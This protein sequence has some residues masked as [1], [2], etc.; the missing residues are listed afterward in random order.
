[1]HG[2]Q[3]T[4]TFYTNGKKKIKIKSSTGIFILYIY[5]FLFTDDTQQG[6]ARHCSTSGLPYNPILFISKRHQIANAVPLSCGLIDTLSNCI[7]H[8]RVHPALEA[9]CS[10]ARTLVLDIISVNPGHKW[11]TNVAGMVQHLQ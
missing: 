5:V 6:Q 2:I 3:H 1:M 9:W 4:T 7:G 10:K 11:T 8:I